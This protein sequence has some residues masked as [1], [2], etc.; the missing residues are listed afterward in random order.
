MK[1]AAVELPNQWETVEMD[2]TSAG[3]QIFGDW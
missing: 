1:V 2:G 3:K